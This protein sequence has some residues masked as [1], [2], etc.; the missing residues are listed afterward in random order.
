MPVAP[1]SSMA[2]VRGIRSSPVT[3]ADD[4]DD[5]PDDLADAFGVR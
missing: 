5:L 2:H 4:F 1:A 3:F